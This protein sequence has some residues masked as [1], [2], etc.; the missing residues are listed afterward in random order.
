MCER[1]REGGGR[2]CGW[3]GGEWYIKRE[4]GGVV[5]LIEGERERERGGVVCLV[6]E[7]ERGVGVRGVVY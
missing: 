1:E 7:R 5:C 6:R 2:V 4:G 3:G